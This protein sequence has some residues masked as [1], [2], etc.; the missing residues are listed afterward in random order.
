MSKKRLLLVITSLLFLIASLL[1]AV[2]VVVTQRQEIRREAEELMQTTYS[3]RSIYDWCSDGPYLELQAVGA[4]YESSTGT[5]TINLKAKRTD[6][7]ALDQ[8]LRFSTVVVGCTNTSSNPN[9]CTACDADDPGYY[10][11]VNNYAIPENQAELD[12]AF[13]VTKPDSGAFSCGCL[14][15]DVHIWDVEFGD[16]ASCNT[17]SPREGHPVHEF[18]Y[19]TS[20]GDNCTQAQPTPTNT[21]Q[22]KDFDTPTPTLIS[23]G[24]PS[25][26]LQPT[27]T[28]TLT[29][30]P[31]TTATPTGTG[32]GGDSVTPTK[33]ISTTPTLTPTK[34]VL[35]TPTP[36]QPELPVAGVET[37]AVLGIAGGIL[38]ILISFVLLL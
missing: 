12:I 24:T 34:T 36:K 4:S 13:K 8:P 38:L 29:Q 19:A 23:T 9:M 25:P 2:Y 15:Q 26:T 3:Q 18:L 6:K 21:I 27:T 35:V 16:Q 1:L 14:Q 20:L 30:T 33:T 5:Q 10:R 32:R 7:V 22:T 28:P 31:T 11:E 17:L 37:P